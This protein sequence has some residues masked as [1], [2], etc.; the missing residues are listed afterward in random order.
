MVLAVPK[1]F[2]SMQM[3][4]ALPG[5]CGLCRIPRLCMDPLRGGPGGKGPLPQRGSKQEGEGQGQAG[6]HQVRGVGVRVDGGSQGF[7]WSCHFL[8]DK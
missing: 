4:W 8:T 5:P 6:D 7:L 2:Q 3:A 1:Q